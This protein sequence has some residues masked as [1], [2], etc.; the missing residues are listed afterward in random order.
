[1]HTI[2]SQ[3]PLT[4][5]PPIRATAPAASRH[6]N[7]KGGFTRARWYG[8]QSPAR[9][10]GVASDP[11]SKLASGRASGR[12][13]TSA[14]SEVSAVASKN[15]VSGAVSRTAS[16]EIS[17]AT[18][19]TASTPAS[20]APPSAIG[21]GSP[22]TGMSS[23]GG[24]V[25][26]THTPSIL[27]VCPEGQT[28]PRHA[29]DKKTSRRSERS[30][31]K[32]LRADTLITSSSNKRSEARIPKP[33]SDSTSSGTTPKLPSS[34]NRPIPSPQRSSPSAAPRSSSGQTAFR[35]RSKRSRSSQSPLAL[36]ASM[37]NCKAFMPASCSEGG[38]AGS[39][40]GRS[41]KKRTNT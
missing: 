40:S 5:A 22:S 25:S 12:A 8:Q 10:G 7:S 26:S 17:C 15:V 37:A 20:C 6:E 19:A 16:R 33:S 30:R 21:A 29:L 31:T 24:T 38:R 27:Q 23:T 39:G 2:P 34:R 3:S 9:M 4:T 18:S 35:S 11:A 13:S 28:T 14:S 1:M 32:P 41:V 36:H